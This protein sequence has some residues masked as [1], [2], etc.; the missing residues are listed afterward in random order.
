MP[1]SG[2]LVNFRPDMFLNITR[3]DFVS[4][5]YETAIWRCRE[6]ARTLERGEDT[7]ARNSL[8]Q[9][10]NLLVELMTT[11]NLVED[12]EI[13]R[14]LLRQYQRMHQRLVDADRNRDSTG[15]KEV[16]SLLDRLA[17]TW[18]QIGMIEGSRET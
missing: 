14:M 18:R 12:G 16:A 15:P 5:L 8:I 7:L 6:A 13:A 17:E 4:M 11:L 10:Q 3:H 9:A 2:M 1:T